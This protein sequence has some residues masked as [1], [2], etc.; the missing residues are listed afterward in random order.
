L[1]H[2]VLFELVATE[3]NDLADFVVREDVLHESLS[4]RPSPTRHQDSGIVQHHGSFW[5]GSVDATAGDSISD[6]G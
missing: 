4:E 3:Y 5:V 1:R 6:D 2:L